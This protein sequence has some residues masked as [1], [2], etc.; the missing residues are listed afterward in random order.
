[1]LHCSIHMVAVEIGELDAIRRQ[2]RDIA[3][4]EEKHIA[5][6]SQNRGHI[7]RNKVF[8]LAQTDHHR[9]TFAGRDDLIRIATAQH[10]QREYAAQFLHSLTHSLLQ[11]AV[12]ILL[13]EVSDDLGIGLGLENVSFLLELLL[14]GQIVLDDAVMDNHNIAGTIAM[15]VRVLF[16]RAP[17][18]RPAGVADAVRAVNRVDLKN[19]FEIPQLAGR[20]ANAQGLIVLKNRNPGR[21]VAAVLK[22]FQAIQ[23]DGDSSLRANVPDYSTHNVIVRTLSKP[24]TKSPVGVCGAGPQTRSRSPDRLP[25]WNSCLLRRAD[26]GV[27]CGSGAPAPAKSTRARR[28]DF[29]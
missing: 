1:M 2:D 29:S 14:Q 10:G 15:R 3:V 27:G 5:S 6:V 22:T 23:N 7:G 24:D 28:L 9:G 16:S 25:V 4:R 17:M 19:V 13:D 12:E 8:A 26:V 21:V 18:C 20:T 11:I